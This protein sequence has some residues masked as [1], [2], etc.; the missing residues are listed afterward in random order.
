MKE[1]SNCILTEVDYPKIKLNS[2]GICDICEVNSAKIKNITELN[3][4]ERLNELV[5]LVK[6]QKKGKY[7]CLIGISGGT[8]SSYLVHLAK[9]WGLNPLLLHIDGGWNSEKSVSNIK[10]IVSI[11]GFDFITE[12]LPWDEM[13]DLQKAFVKANVI[14]IDI[15]FD[16]AVSMYNFY[17]A[18]KYKIK[19]IFNGYSTETEGLMPPNFSHYKCDGRNI[20]HIHKLFG[21]I[22]L[23]DLKI[24]GS[25]KLFYFDKICKIKFVFPLD[26]IRY[27]KS[28]SKEIIQ[29]E[30]GWED[31]GGK[32]YESIYT[33]FYQG[34]ILPRKFK[35]NK[36]KSH[37][38]MLICANQITREDALALD[39]APYYTSESLEKEDQQ[40]FCKKL[41]F[42]TEWFENY[43]LQKE[44]PHRFYKSDFDLYDRVRPVYRFI[45][46]I[47]SKK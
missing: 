8:D 1:C 11:S 33:R 41:D 45:K 9:E 38:S 22:N 30:F 23:K 19:Y 27:D 40:F 13:K 42:S 6:T 16:N 28:K 34:S 25:F 12:V 17:V 3:K 44:V 18:K 20:A 24:L 32:H 37:L 2:K 39:R 46:K 47:F 31:Y 10:K 35:I 7:D 21:T 14:D 26:Y 29:A 4:S 43:L 36:R 5:Q 15:P